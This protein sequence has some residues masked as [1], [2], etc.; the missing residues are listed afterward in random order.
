ML[1]KTKTKTKEIEPAYYMTETNMQALNYKVYYFN[2]AEKVGYFLLAFIV[3]AAVAYL[4]YGG[5]GKNQFGEATQLTYILNVTICTLVGTVAGV[6]FLPIRMEQIITKRK[7]M[8]KMQFRELLDSL[9]TSVGSGKTVVDAFREAYEDLQILFTIDSYMVK[10]LKIINEGLVNNLRIEDMLQNF[11]AR[12]GIEDISSFSNVFDTVYRK[13]GNIKDVIK[14]T[15]QI[16]TEKM[17]V[18]Q[19]IETI[20]TSS[21]T[22]QKIMIA[23]PIALI[24]LIKMMSPEFAANFVTTTGIMATTAAIGIFVVAY[25]VGKIILDIKI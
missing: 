10:E 1:F 6:M 8:L 13:G 18:E 16:I 22:E 25:Y 12:S 2:M 17:E 5:I 11:G 4:F 7:R 14:S 23:M 24:G 20:V 15:H 21:K 19:Q 3:G 9:E